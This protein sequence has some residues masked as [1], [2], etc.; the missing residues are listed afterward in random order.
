[1]SNGGLF[2]YLFIFFPTSMA[3]LHGRRGALLGLFPRLFYLVTVQLQQSHGVIAAPLL[4]L[5]LSPSLGKD[6]GSRFPR[7]L[8][9]SCD[10]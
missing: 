7:S 1:M 9:G 4:Q 5:C 8:T 2:I 6:D 10:A 3:Q